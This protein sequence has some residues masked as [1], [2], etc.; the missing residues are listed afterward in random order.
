MKNEKRQFKIK[1]PVAE[2]GFRNFS[3]F[4]FN[5]SFERKRNGFTLIELVVYVA[6]LSVISLVT[7]NSILILNRT[8]V[9]FR[10]E[11]RLTTSADTAMRRIGRELRLAND[12]YASSTLGV[13]PGV[14]SLS[15]Q[16]SEDDAALK[17][18]MIYTSGGAVI[19]RRATSSP[20]VL[21]GDGVMVTNLMF[22]KITNGTVSKSVKVELTL[23]ALSGSASTTKNYYTTIVLRGSY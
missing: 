18:V 21:T 17:D 15:S 12:V 11:R 20:T 16:E 2:S 4:N 3:F 23:S 5:F 7:V 9:S 13:F 1:N 19:L 22:W 14:L 6:L 8:L 10:L